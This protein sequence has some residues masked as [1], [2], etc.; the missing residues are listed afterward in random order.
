MGEVY[1]ADDTELGRALALK[2]LPE[3]L[4]A[5]SAIRIDWRASS[6]RH[7]RRRR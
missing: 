6:R 3:H 2:V 7:G 5:L 1:R 4:V